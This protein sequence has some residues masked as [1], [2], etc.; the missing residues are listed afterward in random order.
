MFMFIL[1]IICKEEYIKLKASKLAILSIVV[2]L[3][4]I[5]V[6]QYESKAVIASGYKK[7]V[8]KHAKKVAAKKTTKISNTKLKLSKTLSSSDA[9]AV[10]TVDSVS[11]AKPAKTNLM[12]KTQSSFMSPSNTLGL[13]YAENVIKKSANLYKQ[14]RISEAKKTLETES[15]WLVDATEYHTN[16]FRILREVEDAKAQAELE[17]DLA[18]KFAILRD[19]AYYQLALIYIAEK[20]LSKATDN[21]VNIVRSQPDTE[22]GFNSYNQL[23]QIGFTYKVQL[24]KPEVETPDTK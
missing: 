7:N 10:K 11:F 13:T 21:L 12:E 15:D 23:Q 5:S 17:K 24:L 16:V 1:V 14:N 8:E 6:C 19:K 2:S 22:L 4:I 3:S 9:C 18:L 20:N